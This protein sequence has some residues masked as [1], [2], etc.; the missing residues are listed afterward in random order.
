M[1]F[2]WMPDNSAGAYGDSHR[3]NQRIAR[4][5]YSKSGGRA[6]VRAPQGRHALNHSQRSSLAR[7]RAASLVRLAKS[8]GTQPGSAR[9]P[10]GQNG[11]AEPANGDYRGAGRGAHAA[12]LPAVPRRTSRSG[13]ARWRRWA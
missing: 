6:G 5:V 9:R 13:P 8:R 7:S 3:D 1:G 11:P 4:R 10:L 12:R 2:A